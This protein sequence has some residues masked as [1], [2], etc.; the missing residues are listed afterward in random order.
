MLTIDLHQ[1]I[2]R[3]SPPLVTA[4]EDAAQECVRRHHRAVTPQHWLLIRR[5]P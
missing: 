5:L 1:L 4:L 3:L 2:R